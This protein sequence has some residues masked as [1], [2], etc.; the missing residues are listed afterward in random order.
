VDFHTS[1]IWRR[2]DC[3]RSVHSIRSKSNPAT[4]RCTACCMY[5]GGAASRAVE[6]RALNEPDARRSRPC[7]RIACIHP[8]QD[9]E[10]PPPPRTAEL[11]EENSA[12]LCRRAATYPDGTELEFSVLGVGPS[13]SLPGLCPGRPA[14]RGNCGAIPPHGVPAIESHAPLFLSTNNVAFLLG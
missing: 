2:D 13:L 7:W 11:G 4:G 8:S 9:Q 12:V 1:F 10:P 5:L 3:S 6:L 14:T